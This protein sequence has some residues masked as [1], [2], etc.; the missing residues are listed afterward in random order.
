[1]EDTKDRFFIC[2]FSH[3]DLRRRGTRIFK[4][5]YAL[6]RREVLMGAGAAGLYRVCRSA[7]TEG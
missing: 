5:S 4:R 7:V 1:V 3:S 6:P 2:T